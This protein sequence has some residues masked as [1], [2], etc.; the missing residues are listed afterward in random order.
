MGEKLLFK[1]IFYKVNLKWGKATLPLILVL[2]QGILVY[3]CV[4]RM[5]VH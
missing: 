2:S 3:Y 1:S 5:F 4:Y